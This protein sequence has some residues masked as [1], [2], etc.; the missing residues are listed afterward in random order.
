MRILLINVPHPVDRQPHPRRPSAA[1]RPA[2]DRRAADRRR[3][4]GPPA[5]RRV[6]PDADAGDRGG[7]GRAS[8]PTPCCSAIPARPPAIPVIAEVAR[9]I[10]ARHCRSVRIVYGGVFPTYHWREILAEE[11]YVDAIVRGEG[12]ETARQSDAR[13]RNGARRSPAC[14]GIAYRDDGGPRATRAGAGDPRPRRLPRRLGADRP[15]RAT[16]IGA[17]CARSSCSSRAAARTC[18]I[19]AAS[20]ASGRAGAIAIPVRFAEELARLHREHGVEVINF[21]DE[22]PTVSKK[23]WRAFLEALIAENVDADPRRLDARRRHR[24]RCRHPASLQA[25]RLGALPARHGEHR[26]DDARADPQGR[27]R[28]TTDREAIRLLRQHGILSM[29]TWVVG[30]EEETDRDHW[31]GLRQLLSYDP[32][33]IQMLYVTPHRWTPYFRLAADRRGDPDRPAALGLQASGAGH[34]PHAAL[35]R[36]ALVQV[37]RDGAAGAGRRRIWRVLFHPDRG[38][39]HAMRWYTQMGRRVWPYEIF[40]FL[41]DPLRKK[42]PDGRRILGSAAGQRG[43][44]R[45]RRPARSGPSA[46]GVPRDSE[47]SSLRI[48]FLFAGRPRRRP[49]RFRF[50]DRAEKQQPLRS[51]AYFSEHTGCY[52]ED[53]GQSRQRPGHDRFPQP[54]HG[55][56]LGKRRGMARA[57]PAACLAGTVHRYLRR[58]HVLRDDAGWEITAAGRAFLFSLEA[59]TQ[60]NLPAMPEPEHALSDAETR[61]KGDLIVVGYRFQNRIHRRRAPPSRH[62]IAAS[63]KPDAAPRGGNVSK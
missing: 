42:R 52:S 60:D 16:A 53:I 19:I 23:A 39:R 44:I 50:S 15:S 35:A 58:R 14:A 22:N 45:C 61:P 54:R 32:D 9:A 5:R 37:H 6:R 34:A 11:P 27:Q 13:A 30:F 57:D 36:A 24:A 25:G 55:N 10:I 63:G 46:S 33:Q 1:A 7:G 38:L 43:G 18:A 20:A 4:R 59:V 62:A 47:R 29:A 48:T 12:E 31:R 51:R 26:R 3:P 21:A 49:D 28:R 41:R 40:G 17:A 8:R 56:P 2:L